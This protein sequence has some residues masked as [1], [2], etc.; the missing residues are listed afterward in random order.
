M[1][2][3]LHA[4]WWEHF[5][6][7]WSKKGDG[8]CSFPPPTWKYET[9]KGMVK[10]KR[11][12]KRKGRGEEEQSFSRGTAV[13]YICHSTITFYFQQYSSRTEWPQ[14]KWEA[15]EDSAQEPA[16]ER[17]C[18]QI[19]FSWCRVEPLLAVCQ[20]DVLTTVPLMQL[21]NHTAVCTFKSGEI[22]PQCQHSEFVQFFQR[23]HMQRKY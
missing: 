15:P 14:R 10:K 19:L 23:R 4:I 5:Q 17:W 6:R 9:M 3:V 7:K 21:A 8:P 11:R 16:S 18:S 12:E 1:K 22:T 20:T 2:E 13:N